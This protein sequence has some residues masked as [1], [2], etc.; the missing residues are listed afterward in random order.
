MTIVRLRLIRFLVTFALAPG[1]RPNI[2]AQEE[3][4]QGHSVSF[5]QTNDEAAERSPF[6]RSWVWAG[7]RPFRLG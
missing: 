5:A 4:I 3:P 7:S 1:P 2:L 6:V